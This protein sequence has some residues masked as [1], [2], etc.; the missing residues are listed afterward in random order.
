[1]GSKLA[2][3]P[4]IYLA[5]FMGCGKTTVGRLLAEELGWSFVDLD[6]DIEAAAG[7]TISEVFANK[8]E[9]EFRRIEHAAL[10]VRV[11]Q[12]MLGNP[13]VL[14]LGGG[15]FAQANNREL[16][17]EAGLTIWLDAG[18]DL[19]RERIAGQTHRPLAQDPERFKG[20]YEERRHEYAKADFRVPVETNNSAETLTRVLELPLWD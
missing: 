7:A 19:I 12:V 18:L 4:G 10:K 13:F 5:G 1:M 17:G 8:G 14:A 16:L 9:D 3:A 6:D 11:H 2:R 20:L 15:A